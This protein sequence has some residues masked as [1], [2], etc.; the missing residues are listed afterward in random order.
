VKVWFLRGE[1]LKSVTR[2]GTTADEAV[3]HLLAGP[4]EAEEKR[5]VRSHVPPGTP[6]RS[7]AVD[8]RVATVDLGHEFVDSTDAESLL[9]RLTQLVYTLNG[10]QRANEVRLLVDGKPP[11]D[12]FPGVSAAG[13]ITVEYL[14]TPNV[15]PAEP[16]TVRAARARTAVSAAQERLVELGYL[17]PGDVDGR[18]GPATQNAILAFQKWEGL[19]RDGVLGA[20][21]SA[22][23]KTAVRPRPISRGGSGKRAEVLV[24]RQV[25]LLIRNNRVV[26]AIPVSSGKPS[27][28]TPPGNYKVYAKFARWWSVPFREWLLWAIPFTGGIAFHQ[29]PQ[30]PTYPA[31]HGCV[32]ESFVVAKWTYDFASV[33]MPVKVIARSV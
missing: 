17:L 13:P 21:T 1:Q 3:R 28:P 30:V 32:R 12:V 24:D 16:P 11:P 22:R 26:R 14:E 9:A 6:V 23:L 10:R 33:G 7:I 8:G 15:V 2:P 4:T 20:K 18:P 19:E 31:S 29:F 25:A 5:G 27:T